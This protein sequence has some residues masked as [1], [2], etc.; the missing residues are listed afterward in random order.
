METLQVSEVFYSIQGEGKTMGTP[1]IFVRLTGCNLLCQGS[2]I[3]DTIEVWRKGNKT[4]F[5]QILTDRM[6]WRLKQGAHLIITGGE[7]L[8]QQDRII[9]YLKWFMD[10]YKFKPFVEIE[11]NGTLPIKDQMK[12]WLVDLWNCSPKLSNSGEPLER[13]YNDQVVYELN[14]LHTI[15]KFVI[16]STKDWNEIYY[17]YL[18][19]GIGREKIWLMP[20]ADN[21]DQL[22]ETNRIVAKIALEN[23]VNFCTRLQIE[24]WNK[25]TGV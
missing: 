7:P 16:T 25:T 14:Q 6:I 4:P 15:F 18:I 13:R 2:W 23:Q 21:I 11:T 5:D 10:E 9:D 1:S 12:L 17:N 19:K 24:I 20:G 8:L 22:L 3:C